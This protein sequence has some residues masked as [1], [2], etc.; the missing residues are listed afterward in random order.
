MYLFRF[1]DGSFSNGE[2]AGSIGLAHADAD[3]IDLSGLD[4]D[5]RF[6]ASV[7]L[8][9]RGDRLAV[10]APGDDG[11]GNLHPQD[12]AAYLFSFADASFAGGKL[13]GIVGR[14]YTESNIHVPQ[15]HGQYLFGGSVSL[16][17]A[18]DRLAVGDQVYGYGSG[19]VGAVYL[20]TFADDVFTGGRLAAIVGRN[21]TDENIDLAMLEESDLFG[22]SVS[23]N[24]SGD[25]LAVGAP[26]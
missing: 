5:D 26:L 24:A 11:P 16:N 12:G 7:S 6:G 8:N 23:L 19:E 21:Q 14:Q 13:A 9:A 1:A 4:G 17:A 3:S 25:R 2:L 18:G 20:F 22:A 10:G 15:T